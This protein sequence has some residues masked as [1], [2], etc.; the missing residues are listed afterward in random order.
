MI[1]KLYET[2]GGNRTIW[3]A[4]ESFYRRVL[5]DK[6][7]RP[8]FESVD[9]AKLISGQSMFLSMLLGGRVVYTGK[10][11]G[12]A[13]RQVRIQGL[14]DAH[15]DAFLRHFRASL[16]EVG[17]KPDKAEQVMKLLEAKRGT[18]LNS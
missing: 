13:H 10:E 12:A 16:D 11:L 4:T 5:A 17:V 1:D 9:M 7:L 6:D 14:T 15:F 18:V 2:I 8:F 3:A